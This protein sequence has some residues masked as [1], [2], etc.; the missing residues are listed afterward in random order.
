MVVSPYPGHGALATT[1]LSLD[2]VSV[3]SKIAT[4]MPGEN[5]RAPGFSLGDEDRPMDRETI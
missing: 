2:Y 3:L 1:A 5:D 4:D